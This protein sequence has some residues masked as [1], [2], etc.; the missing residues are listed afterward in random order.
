MSLSF[1]SIAFVRPYAARRVTLW[2][3]ARVRSEAGY[4]SLT[5]FLSVRH[6]LHI[7]GRRI[8]VDIMLWIPGRKETVRAFA[9]H[10]PFRTV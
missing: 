8:A 10:R 7:S 3:L 5:F 6:L 9:R 1:A 2:R 4:R